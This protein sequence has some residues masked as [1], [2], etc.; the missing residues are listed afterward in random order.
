MTAASPVW[1]WKIETMADIM[2]DMGGGTYRTPQSGRPSRK[3]LPARKLRL[4]GIRTDSR[5][6]NGIM[7]GQGMWKGEM[8][9][10]QSM[11]VH[12]ITTK[13]KTKNDGYHLPVLRFACSQ[14]MYL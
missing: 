5:L 11:G 2:T 1:R 4:S 6:Q 9:V 7:V 10:S 13:L 14:R 8:V 12:H 3:L